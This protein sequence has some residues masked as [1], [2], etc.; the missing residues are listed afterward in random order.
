MAP[1]A[2]VETTPRS[3][4]IDRSDDELLKSFLEDRDAICPLCG[5]NLRQLRSS[6]CPECGRELKLTVGLAQPFMAAWITLVVTLGASAG[7]GAF[8]LIAICKEGIPESRGGSIVWYFPAMMPLV[9]LVIVTRRTFTKLS[10]L[11]QWTVAWSAVVLTA[12]VF[13]IMIALVL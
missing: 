5:Y 10:K 4:R 1:E 9:G 3:S 13:I 6:R 11:A 2:Q 12:I 7:I 8:F